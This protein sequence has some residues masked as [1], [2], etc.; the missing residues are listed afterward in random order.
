[1]EAGTEVPTQTESKPFLGKRDYE[2]A[3]DKVEVT[4]VK[5]DGQENPNYD[6]KK[7]AFLLTGYPMRADAQITWGQPEIL[8]REFG[9]T[10]YEIDGRPKGHFEGNSI[11]LE[12]EGIRQFASEVEQSGVNEI[13]LYGHSIGASKAVDLAVALEQKNPKLRVNVVL[14]NP[15]GMYPQDFREI[16][17]NYVIEAPKVER[18]TKNPD[19]IF[20]PRMKVLIDICASLFKDLKAA[21]LQYPKLFADQRRALTQLNAN[22]TRIESPVL[23]MLA[24]DD[25][26]VQLERIFPQ[27]MTRVGKAREQYL[28]KN[29]LPQAADVRVIVATKYANH[30]A[31]GVERPRP[32]SH[33]IARYFDRLRR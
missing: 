29:V 22:L 7:A 9:V 15:L 17:K 3:G 12:V 28:K 24:L 26:V 25:P 21:K 32:T 13:T 10:T 18:R 33:V 19:R 2:L 31:F 5:F 30:I 14:I 4:F 1:M 8:A 23:I 27:E 20:Q 16:A 6:P 11:N